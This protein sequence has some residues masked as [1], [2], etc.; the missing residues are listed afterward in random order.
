MVASGGQG[1]PAWSRAERPEFEGAVPGAGGKVAVVGRP[2]ARPDDAR[3]RL[4]QPPQ[5]PEPHSLLTCTS[6]STPPSALSVTQLTWPLGNG[7]QPNSPSCG[8][9]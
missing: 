2:G 1:R 7:A 8:K 9:A 3:V 6:L 4:H 5:H